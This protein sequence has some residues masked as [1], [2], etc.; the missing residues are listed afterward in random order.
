MQ[1]TI[2]KKTG[3]LSAIIAVLMGVILLMAGSHNGKSNFL[4]MNHSGTQYQTTVTSTS[5]IG[6]DTMFFQMMIPH[7]QQAVDIS[8]LAIVTSKDSELIALAKEIRDGQSSEIVQ[9]KAWLSGDGQGGS[10]G[11]PMGDGVGGMLTSSE[12]A[13]LKS[14][15]GSAFDVYWLKKMI[16]H[17]QGAI[18]MV[19]MIQDSPRS[20]ILAFGQNI[21]KVQSA[22]I[23]QMNQM[24]KRLGA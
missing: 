15:K 8:A 22:Q 1:I 5:L 13:T 18:H 9:M 21:D 16:V 14:L 7:H 10:A 2:D 3:I 4:G 17:H 12:V 6:S 23:N 20:D 24:L 11:H 19:T